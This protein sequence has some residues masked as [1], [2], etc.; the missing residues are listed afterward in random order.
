[1][2][3]NL[4]GQKIELSKRIEMY[5]KLKSRKTKSLTEI[6]PLCQING[7]KRKNPMN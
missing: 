2:E 4:H 7:S 6:K 5:N 3:N 1:M